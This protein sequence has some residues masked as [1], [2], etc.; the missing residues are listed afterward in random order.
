MA[1]PS[2][3]NPEDVRKRLESGGKIPFGQYLSMLRQESGVSLA[4]FS[5]RIQCS[6]GFESM[7]E[8]GKFP[9]E[10]IS[11]AV[12]YAAAD[13]LHLNGERFL[14]LSRVAA[15]T[16]EDH[17]W[18]HNPIEAVEDMTYI[19]ALHELGSAALLMRAYHRM[20]TSPGLLTALLNHA[21]NRGVAVATVLRQTIDAGHLLPEHIIVRMV[22]GS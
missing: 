17:E 2:R 10:R 7:I 6:G 16:R 21:G 19:K 5:Y 22:E 3:V 18:L 14:L 1:R 12:V 13:V 15:V 8:T 4:D 11:S 20:L 9:S